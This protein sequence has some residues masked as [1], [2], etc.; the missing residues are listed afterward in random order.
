MLVKCYKHWKYYTIYSEH[1]RKKM[2][3]FECI[4]CKYGWWEDVMDNPRTDSQNTKLDDNV[5]RGRYVIQF[6]RRLNATLIAEELQNNRGR[7]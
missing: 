5:G 7:V 3:V 4:R 1:A 6:D 2:N